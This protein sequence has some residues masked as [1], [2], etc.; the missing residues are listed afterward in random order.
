MVHAVLTHIRAQ[1]MGALSLFL[2]IA[3]GTAYAANTIGSSDI[4]NESILSQDVRNGEVQS[5]DIGNNQVAS[6]D[7]RDDTLANGGLAPV[8][9][10]PGAVG[11]SEVANSSVRGA[12]IATG[13][14]NSAEVA[15]E[16]LTGGDVADDSLTGGDVAES[17]LGQV[18]S[19]ALGGIGR[20][21]FGGQCDPEGAT[22]LSCAFTTIVLPAPSRV[23]VIGSVKAQPEPGAD[24]GT[25]QC[26]LATNNGTITSSGLN[27]VGRNYNDKFVPLM[28]I[29]DAGPGPLDF[30]IECNEL[31]DYLT[32]YDAHVI[33]VALSPS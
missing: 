22:F 28:G 15:D 26:R 12:D 33:A 4:I 32:F 25:G 7:V 20:S 8:D 10:R 17:T 30:G 31:S 11:T 1:W 5:A 2:V 18:P 16:S 21:A 29:T 27:A 9:L 13:A 6:A 14:V 19:A 24:L 23:L 3:G